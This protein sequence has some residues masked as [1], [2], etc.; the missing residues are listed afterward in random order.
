[1]KTTR[2]FKNSWFLLAIVV[3]IVI[4]EVIAWEVASRFG[5]RSHPFVVGML[6]VGLVAA[7]VS[8]LYED[9]DIG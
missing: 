4:G 2:T 1:M 6:S 7:I 9:M 5:V 3:G 8:V